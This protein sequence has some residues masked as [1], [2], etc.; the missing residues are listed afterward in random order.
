MSEELIDCGSKEVR[1]REKMRFDRWSVEFD[2]NGR[3]ANSADYIFV[4]KINVH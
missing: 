4:V 1:K 3:S 2:L